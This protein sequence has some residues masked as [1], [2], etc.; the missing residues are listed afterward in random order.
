M[1][2]FVP[3]LE[4]NRR[5]YFEAVNP[6][7]VTDFPNLQFSAARIGKGSEVLGYDTPLS[8]DHDWGPR[9][10]LFLRA[11]VYEQFQAEVIERLRHRLPR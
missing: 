2:Q 9:L 5:F 4:L 8:T 6:I 7:L 3:G 11:S 10:Q 1:N